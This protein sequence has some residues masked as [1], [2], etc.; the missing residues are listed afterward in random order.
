MRICPNCDAV[1]KESAHY[2]K[3]CGSRLT[4]EEIKATETVNN[5]KEQ[6]ATSEIKLKDFELD[7][8]KLEQKLSNIGKIGKEIGRIKAVSKK[9]DSMENM[10]QTYDN[11]LLELKSQ[12]IEQV[13]DAKY[14]KLRSLTRFR[15]ELD[16]LSNRLRFLE[17]SDAN[18]DQRVA[19]INKKL[20]QELGNLGE[21]L[22][23]KISSLKTGLGSEMQTMNKYNSELAEIKEKVNKF[24]TSIRVLEK[25]SNEIENANKKLNKLEKDVVSVSKSQIRIEEISSHLRDLEERLRKNNDP[26]NSN[27]NQID[28]RLNV[29]ES[30]LDQKIEEKLSDVKSGLNFED[31][32][33]NRQ[34]SELEN[35][36]RKIKGFEANAKN[37]YPKIENFES[38]IKDVENK[39]GKV[40]VLSSGI[41]KIEKEFDQLSL[42]N[43]KMVQDMGKRFEKNLDNM[44][45][46]KSSQFAKK[47]G[48]KLEEQIEELQQMLG[49]KMPAFGQLKT[50]LKE[51]KE[52]ISQIKVSNL[53]NIQHQTAIK[54]PVIRSFNEIK[55]AR[56]IEPKTI[57]RKAKRDDSEITELENRI[58]N[59]ESALRKTVSSRPIVIE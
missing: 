11:K 31:I 52:E 13:K 3:I 5:L 56:V 2:C 55:K 43:E 50:E 18:T 42:R 34:N 29:L 16:S 4:L 48:F 37:T 41:K 10:E 7:L 39:L 32:S 12:V 59:L 6:Y 54:E 47:L 23:K 1:N 53:T 49:R 26:L 15:D 35:L 25:L 22:H 28:L 9:L 8:R 46:N 30:S 57:I 20:Q 14:Y 45:K 40:R 38:R 27:I 51:L 17:K 21:S 44:I 58:R 33:L 24:N 36:K 19:F